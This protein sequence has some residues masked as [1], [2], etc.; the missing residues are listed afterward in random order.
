MAT[1]QNQNMRD[2]P[3]FNPLLGLGT[4]KKP[5]WWQKNDWSFFFFK[6]AKFVDPLKNDSWPIVGDQDSQCLRCRCCFL[7]SGPFFLKKK[8][9]CFC[10]PAFSYSL[11]AGCSGNVIPSRIRPG[12]GLICQI[13]C[14][15]LKVSC[16]F[17]PCK[18]IFVVFFSRVCLFLISCLEPG[19]WSAQASWA[20]PRDQ[21]ASV[22]SSFLSFYFPPSLSLLL[23]PS[24]TVSVFRRTRTFATTTAV[25]AKEERTIHTHAHT[26]RER[27][28]NERRRQ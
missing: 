14:L 13:L 9:F 3:E 17:F 8:S 28:E 6:G 4:G 18:S 15:R 11:C 1:P 10:F 21:S 5:S 26:R 24:T 16:S 20:Q 12:N 7:E 25:H 27:E 23:F 2:E 22:G 19:A